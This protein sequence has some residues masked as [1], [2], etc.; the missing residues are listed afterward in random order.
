MYKAPRLKGWSLP[1]IY[2]TGLFIRDYLLKHKTAYPQEIWRAL[3]KKRSELKIYTCTYESFW[4][5]YIYVLRKLG[6]IR[7]VRKVKPTKAE[8]FPKTLYMITPGME[9]DPRWS[10]PQIALDPRRGMPK[11]RRMYKTRKTKP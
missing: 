4:R 9:N 2:P 7:R 6:L 8:W 5:N 3:K 10:H 1:Y 11:Y